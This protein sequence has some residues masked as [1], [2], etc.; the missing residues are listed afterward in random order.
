MTLVLDPET[1]EEALAGWDH[2]DALVRLTAELG[3]DIAQRIQ[4]LEGR[5]VTLELQ[6]RGV[7]RADRIA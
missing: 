1:L 6:Q 3:R 7:L 2:P 5:V 4:A